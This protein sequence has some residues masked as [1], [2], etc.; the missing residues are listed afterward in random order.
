MSRPFTGIMLLLTALLLLSGC[1]ADRSDAVRFGLATAPINLDPRFATDAV[2]ERVNRLLYRAPVGFDAAQRPVP[3][4]ATWRVLSPRVYRLTLG[5]AG[6]IFHDGTR[7]TAADVAA[8]YA[9]ILDPATASPHRS[10]LRLIDRIRVIDEDRLDFLLTRAD[11]LFPSYLSVGILPASRIAAGDNLATQPVGSGPFRFLRWPEAGHL[12]LE[13]IDDRQQFVF[14]K[15]AD[16]TMR[17]LKLVRG[18]IDLLQNDLPPELV[19]WLERRADVE[20][21]RLRGDNFA[22]LGFN[23]DDPALSNPAVRKAI[24]L[25]L[26]RDTIIRYLLAGGARPASGLLPPEHWAGAA[27]LT[28][29]TTDREEARRLLAEAGYTQDS[30]LTLTYKTSADPLRLRIATAIQQQLRAV[31]IEVDIRSYDWGTFYGDIKAGRF[32]LFSLAWV[33]VRTPDI[34]RYAFHSS[35]LPP[36]GANRGRFRDTRVDELIDA[37]EAATSVADK[38]RLYRQLQ[39]LLLEALPVVPLWYEDQFAAVRPTLRGYAVA[40]DGNYDALIRVRRSDGT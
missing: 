15:V 21:L 5:A 25:A 18:E 7:L 6:R 13:R 20:V 39:A 31:A 34:F 2:S 8:T 30:P 36:E 35:S 14:E 4:L 17:V 28:T 9:S 23:L 16:A 29:L 11:T 26:D 19:G 37:A 33:G 10:Q 22:Y 38:A 12:E 27:D 40:A 3:D 1:S 32:Q 24:A